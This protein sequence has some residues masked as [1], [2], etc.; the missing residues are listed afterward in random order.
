ML[1]LEVPKIVAAHNIQLRIF[2]AVETDLEKIFNDALENTEG[3]R[4]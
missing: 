2:E 4:E 1:R 3:G